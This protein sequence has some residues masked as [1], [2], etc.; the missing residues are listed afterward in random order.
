M[1]FNDILEALQTGRTPKSIIDSWI[2][3]LEEQL[4]ISKSAA[5]AMAERQVASAQDVLMRQGKTFGMEGRTNVKLGQPLGGQGLAQQPLPIPNME[6]ITERSVDDPLKPAP[7]AVG[8]LSEILKLPQA[9]RP[10]GDNLAI[11]SQL[12]AGKMW[13]P[14]YGNWVDKD[15][16]IIRAQKTEEKKFTSGQDIS[17]KKVAEETKKKSLDP[18]VNVYAPDPSDEGQNY[19]QE[20]IFSLGGALNLDPTARR[21]QF[22]QVDLSDYATALPTMLPGGS[23]APMEATYQGIVPQLYNA[24]KM[25]QRLGDIPGDPNALEDATELVND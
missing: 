22:A 12:D 8:S 20:G 1:D 2:P 23:I 6:M 19:A 24:F 10:P 21:T 7:K 4:G 18:P 5:K 9:A 16:A 11:Q 17:S 15:D 14:L 13:H 3:F 25:A